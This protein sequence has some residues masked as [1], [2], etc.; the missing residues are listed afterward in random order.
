MPVDHPAWIEHQRTRWTRHDAHRWFKPTFTRKA[1]SAPRA[2]DDAFA[3]EL[4]ALQHDHLELK[5]LF[6][7]HRLKLASQAFMAKAYNPNQI[8]EKT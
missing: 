3:P 6:A 1:K 4:A 2:R 7:E 5:W 8:T